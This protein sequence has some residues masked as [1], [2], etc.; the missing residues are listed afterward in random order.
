MICFRDLGVEDVSLSYGS[1]IVFFEASTT[2][3]RNFPRCFRTLPR[4]KPHAHTHPVMTR[5]LLPKTNDKQKRLSFI[6]DPYAPCMVYLHIFYLQNCVIFRANVGKYSSTMEQGDDLEKN[7]PRG[8]KGPFQ[9]LHELGQ[10]YR[11]AA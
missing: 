3:P 2:L 7:H 10:T 9:A 8:A 4:V 6:Y 5:R 1:I 11:L